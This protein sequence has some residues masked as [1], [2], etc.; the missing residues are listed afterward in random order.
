MLFAN[1]ASDAV[2]E[3][4]RNAAGAWQPDQLRALLD[5]GRKQRPADYDAIVRGLAQRY[6][7]DQQAIIRT[8][9]SKAY[10]KTGAAMPIDPVNWL[11]FFARQDS[12][13]Y[14]TPAKRELVDDAEIGRAH[15]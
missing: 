2:I 5:A 7:G 13:V 10:P 6:A 15:V 4:I 9:L 3:Q 14:I 11:R 8:A 12:G 1:A